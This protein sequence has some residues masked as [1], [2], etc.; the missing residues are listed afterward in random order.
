MLFAPTDSSYRSFYS[1]SSTPVVVELEQPMYVEVFVV[2]HQ[3]KDLALL[4][5]DCWATPTED[6]HE[7]HRWNLIVKG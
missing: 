1:S 4:L 2:K 5:E 6:P 3:N 7:P